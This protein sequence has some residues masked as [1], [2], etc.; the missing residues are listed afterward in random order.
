LLARQGNWKDAP[1]KYD[2][3]V[4]YAPNWEAFKRARDLAAQKL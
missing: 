2:A 1:T 4:Q 3:A